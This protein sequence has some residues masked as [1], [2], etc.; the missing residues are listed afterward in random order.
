MNKLLR[1]NFILMILAMLGASFLQFFRPDL[2]GSQSAFGL[3]PDWQREIAFWNLAVIPIFIAC[4]Y[5]RDYFFTKV[6]A[7]SVMIGGLGFAS[8]HLMGWLAQPSATGNLVGSLEN[9]AF[10]L[11]WLI[12]LGIEIKKHKNSEQK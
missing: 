10:V 6:C 12:G 3:A 8:N 11:L 9:F 1:F 2:L 7:S 4:L 5:K